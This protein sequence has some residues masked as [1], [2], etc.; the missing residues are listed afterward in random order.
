[1]ERASHDPKIVITTYEGHH[2]HDSPSGRTVNHNG[3]AKTPTTNINGDSG[4]KSQGNSVRVNT[5]EPTCL[6]S[7]SRL[8]EQS[9]GEKIAKPHSGNM[10]ES[11]VIILPSKVLGNTSSEKEQNGNSGTRK[12]SVSVD[13]ISPTDSEH[14]CR[15]DEQQ[16]DEVRTISEES[17]NENKLNKRF[18]PDAEPV[19]R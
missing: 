3:A 9:N 10:V 6:D 18:E 13:L 2:D 7:E 12:D 5:T 17:K 11:Q 4:T 16:K 8:N 14:P 1:M 19:Q 15:L